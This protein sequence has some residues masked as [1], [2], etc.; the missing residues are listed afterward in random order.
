MRNIR[1]DICRGKEGDVGDLLG[2]KWA[3]SDVAMLAC[4][5][6]NLARLG[7]GAVTRWRIAADKGIE[8]RTRSGTVAVS[9]YRHGVDMVYCRSRVTVLV[10]CQHPIFAIKGGRE[11]VQKG[12]FPSCGGNPEK[13]TL[14]TTPVPLALLVAFTEPRMVVLVKVLVVGNVA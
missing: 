14:N 3:G 5:I 1:R 8:V 9:R 2:R 7:S 11:D 6:A 13:L 4:K 10:H 12:P